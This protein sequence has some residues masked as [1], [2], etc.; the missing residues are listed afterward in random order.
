MCGAP[1]LAGTTGWKQ[2]SGDGLAFTSTP[3]SWIVMVAASIM[4][5]VN[6]W[7]SMDPSDPRL[8]IVG[9]A[10]DTGSVEADKDV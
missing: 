5:G 1:S 4:S 2:W 3:G 10:D 9:E 8:L 7:R 6:L